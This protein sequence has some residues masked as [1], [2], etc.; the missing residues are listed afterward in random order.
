MAKASPIQNSF[1]AGEFAPEMEGRT[2][3]AKYGAAVRRMENG[4]PLV[5]GPC[6]RRGGTKFI[7]EV[8]ASANRT[9][10][11]RFE[12]NTDQAY[13][14]E[15]GDLYIRFFTDNGTASGALLEAT[16]NITGIT[17]ANPGVLTY[18]GADPANGDWMYLTGIGG[19]TQLNG[20][21]VKVANVNAGANTFELDEIDGTNISTLTY[22]AYTAGGT[23]AR[24]YTLTSPYSAADLINADGSFALQMVQS[25]DILFICHPSHPPKELARLGAVSW[26]ITDYVYDGGPFNDYDPDQTTTVY[27]SAATGVGVT[28]TASAASFAAT[29]V[30]RMIYLEQK[31]ANAITMWETA[32]VVAAGARRRSDGKTYYTAAGGTTGNVRPTHVAGSSSDGDTGVI[33]EYEDPGYGWAEIT[34]YTSTTVITVT[35]LSPIPNQCVLV[36]NA[37][38]RWALSS[39]GS[40][41][42][43]PSH[44]T[45]FR[46]RLAFARATDRKIWFSV[47][48]DYY[49]FSDRDDAGIV[50]TDMAVTV[51][52][53]SDESNR[54]QY[55]MPGDVLVIGTANGEHICKEMTDSEPF[56]PGNVTINSSSKYG[57]RNVQPVS[58]GDSILFVQRSGRKLRE[59]TYDSIRG[60]AGS[61]D[62]SIMAPH[63][64]PKGKYIIQMAYQKEPHSIVWVVLNDGLLRGF[65]FNR[66][67]YA[68]PPFGGW[69]RH[70]IGGSGIVESIACIPSPSND[71]DD[72]WLVVRRTIN[73]NSVRYIELMQAEYEAGD[74]QEDA[75]YV[76]CGLTYDDVPADVISGLRHLEG[77]TVD[78]LADG[79]THPQC[80]VTGGSI[81]LQLEA[82]VIQIGL[83]CP[84]K[85]ATLR[86]EAGAQDGTAQGKTKRINR[87]VVRLLD[88]LGGSMGPSETTVDEILF[89]DG[90][91]PMDS[92][93]PIFTGDKEVP[94]PGGYEKEGYVWYVNDSPLPATI[95]AI[96]PSVTTQDR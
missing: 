38:T 16:Q 40:V 10:L 21:T 91:D 19:M 36:G 35:V 5:Q 63:M 39:W 7:S 31:K 17:Q 6:R 61:L 60:E 25:G 96:M 87:L 18:A 71:R 44:V 94:W 24:V 2:D 22:G 46:N 80:V 47:A 72:L 33:W 77:K 56:G 93:P 74:A 53:E 27:A 29:D 95:V 34:G 75:F 85:L 37:T 1:N 89:R 11:A 55:I 45:F 42:G 64:V 41:S 15:F 28:I 62:M 30:G 70:T 43:Y 76:D 51:T 79:A 78:V 57:S 50:T 26:T 4:I 69:H 86:L 82:S 8:K 49:D 52:V 65:T 12:F 13:I 90:S 67:Q 84:F 48:G 20:K 66:E 59:I 9:W 58:V 81:T 83:P 23:M 73:G 14:L 54:I 88:T 3:I 32:K 68:D 92:A